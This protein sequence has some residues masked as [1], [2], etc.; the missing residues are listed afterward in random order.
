MSCDRS[1]FNDI[2]S[3]IKTPSEVQMTLTLILTHLLVSSQNET[4]A[5][6]SDG[7]CSAVVVLDRGVVFA[8]LS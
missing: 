6:G 5:A 4:T 8:T 3:F 1:Y 2:Q 7:F